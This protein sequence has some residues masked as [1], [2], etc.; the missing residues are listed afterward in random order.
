MKRYTVAAGLLASC[1]WV[2]ASPGFMI[3][4]SYNFGGSVGVTAKVLSSNREN[5]AVAAVGASYLFGESKSKFGV[6]LGAGYNFKHATAT[7]GWEPDTFGHTLQMP[8]MLR[9]AG[10]DYYYFCRGGKGK[11]GVGVE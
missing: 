3:G 9:L 6:D 1:S 4:I 11:P 8:Q 7:V 2:Q 10:C 5:R